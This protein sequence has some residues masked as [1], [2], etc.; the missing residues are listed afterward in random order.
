MAVAP[1]T[2]PVRPRYECLTHPTISGLDY[3]NGAT[4]PESHLTT[5]A[6]AYAGYTGDDS[7]AFVLGDILLFTLSG[8]LPRSFP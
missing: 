6:G 8:N 2:A 1:D 4:G 3:L 5:A 7:M